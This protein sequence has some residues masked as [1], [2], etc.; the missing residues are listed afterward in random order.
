MKIRL[1]RNTKNIINKTMYVNFK[2]TENY[3]YNI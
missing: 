1:P 3:I 2:C